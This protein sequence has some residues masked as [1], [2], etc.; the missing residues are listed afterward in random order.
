MDW[1][2]KIY[3]CVKNC[4]IWVCVCGLYVDNKFILLC[5]F[6]YMCGVYV[7]SEF[8]GVFFD[9][10]YVNEDVCFRRLWWVVIILSNYN[11]LIF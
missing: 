3:N 7:L 6:V 9:F 1:L 4:I 2:G 5:I 11:K 10:V 8:W